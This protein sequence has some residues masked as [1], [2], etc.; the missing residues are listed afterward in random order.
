MY[1]GISLSNIKVTSITNERKMMQNIQ[2]RY[3][4]IVRLYRLEHL[5]GLRMMNISDERI[6][7]A[8][9]VLKRIGLIFL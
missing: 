9:N 2:K 6:D 5:W 8:T 7:T 4:K 1:Q 3:A